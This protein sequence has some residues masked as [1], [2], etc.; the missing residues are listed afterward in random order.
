M[1]LLR[2][3]PCLLELETV[4]ATLRHVYNT[5]NVFKL[6]VDIFN[7][8]CNSLHSLVLN[9]KIEPFHT[10]WICVSVLSK[11]PPTESVSDDYSY[12]D[13]YDFIKE[14][15]DTG[16]V[17]AYIDGFVDSYNT[18]N[19]ILCSTPTMGEGMVTMKIGNQYINHI[20][21]C[22]ESGEI[23]IELPLIPC[24]FSFL[25]IKYTHP[26][27]DNVIYLDIDKNY[28]FNGNKILSPLFIKKYL[29]H[30]SRDYYFDMDY[31]I[32]IMDNDVE[33]FY[34]SSNQYILL[35]DSTYSIVTKRP[36]N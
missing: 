16:G 20:Y 2:R 11:K 25:S 12:L 19:S 31:T 7:Y 14:N 1:H 35:G 13:T 33:T 18:I 8:S 36:A 4:K 29:R 3:V 26:I 28:Y 17:E 5:N 32:E 9:Y 34:L 27:M 24:N 15:A 22:E 21:P 23:S 10:N 6:S 30:Q